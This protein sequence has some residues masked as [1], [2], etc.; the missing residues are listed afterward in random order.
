[1]TFISLNKLHERKDYTSQNHVQRRVGISCPIKGAR[2]TG[3]H[4]T[5]IIALIK[6]IHELSQCKMPYF[7]DKSDRQLSTLSNRT[8][9]LKTTK[10]IIFLVLFFCHMVSGPM[11]EHDNL[12]KIDEDMIMVITIITEQME[13][14]ENKNCSH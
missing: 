5:V 8:S 9:H 7:L 1:M 6:N 12:S 3:N 11:D 4:R 13:V 14:L 10:N 2:E